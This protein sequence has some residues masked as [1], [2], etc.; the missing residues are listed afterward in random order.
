M[1]RHF[2]WRRVCFG[3]LNNVIQ[4]VRAYEASEMVSHIRLKVK[5]KNK[6]EGESEEKMAMLA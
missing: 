2:Q 4:V 3:L 1:K 6:L 5:V